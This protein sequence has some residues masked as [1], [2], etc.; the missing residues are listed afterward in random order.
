VFFHIG[1]F[2]GGN[3]PKNESGIF[4]LQFILTNKSN[5]FFLNIRKTLVP[6]NLYFCE[7]F[8]KPSTMK[9]KIILV[10]LAVLTAGFVSAQVT[11]QM[12]GAEYC[13]HRKSI[14]PSY[15]SQQKDALANLP[16]SYDVQNYTLDLDIF[17][18][19]MTPFPQ[20]YAAKNTITFMV[21]STLNSIQLNCIATSMT[22][23]S[24]RMA[25]TSFSQDGDILTVQLDRTYNPGETVQVRISYHHLDVEDGGFNASGGF[26]FT[27]CEPEGARKWFPCWDKPSDKATLDLTAKV[28]LGARLGSNGG[29]ADS[30]ING[31]TLTYHWVST[32]KIA[33][34]LM[35]L[36]SRLNYKIDIVP[37]HKIS[38]PS[39]IVP[40]MFYYNNGETPQYIESILGD[41]TTYYSENFCEHPF[42]KN[43]FATL[44]EEFIWGGMENQ[45]LTS[46]CP[47]CWYES[48]VSHE[49]AHQWFGD[50]VT[51]ATWADIW[52]NEGFATWTEAFWVE[53]SSGYTGY[54]SLISSDANAYLMNNPG[55]AISVPDWAV[56]TPD[57]SILFNYYVTYAKGACALHQ[58]RYLLGDTVFF[59]VMQN[60]VNDPTLRFGPATIADFNAKVNAASGQNYDWYFN[61]W[62]FQPNHPSYQNTYNVQDLGGGQW[63][64]NLFVTQNQADP[65]FFRMR[66]PIRILFE[67][68]TD[69]IFSIMNDVNYQQYSFLFDKKPVRLYFDQENMV[70]LKEATT[71]VGE[72]ELAGLGYNLMQNFPNPAG[73]QTR[74]IYETDQP[75]NV[76]IEILDMT[77]RILTVPFDEVKPAGKYHLDLNCSDF[78]SGV[79]YYRIIVNGIS[80]TKK[81]IITKS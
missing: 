41:M 26:V 19:F 81:M 61:D 46:L 36:T 7:L 37:W 5:K 47:D 68:G 33:T 8:N 1:G 25:G 34:Y 77:G 80:Q 24:V 42:Q 69:S 4:R 10:F 67:N 66:F 40:L 70:V 31:D 62:I 9:R 59:Q 6:G 78:A 28:P 74:I 75:G 23:D 58:L 48:I 53:K 32:D 18:C 13:S 54:K 72:A 43:G 55:W 38:N 22:V 17:H 50:L 64:V 79:Y 30:T 71:L 14:L 12:S 51:C 11:S 49:Y 35:V 20:D 73:D 45:T 27:D 16:H 21:D 60:Y 76:R 3:E 63:S 2:S 57:N 39:V 52:L 29:L 15:R 44:N 56:N 65:A